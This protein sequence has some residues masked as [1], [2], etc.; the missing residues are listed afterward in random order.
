MPGPS[1]GPGEYGGQGCVLVQEQVRGW[2]L[3]VLFSQVA[4]NDLNPGV[5]LLL[6]VQGGATSYLPALQVLLRVAKLL[7]HLH[8]LGLSHHT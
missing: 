4:L 3:S 2:P 6:Q 5:P 1:P 8:S 7:A